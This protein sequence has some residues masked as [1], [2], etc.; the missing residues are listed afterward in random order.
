MEDSATLI[1]LS[2]HPEK[3]YG[4][5]EVLELSVILSWKKVQVVYKIHQRSQREEANYEL[6]M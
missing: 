5:V 2:D 1:T 6:T 4:S 3:T